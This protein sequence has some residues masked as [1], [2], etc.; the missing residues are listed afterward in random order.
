MIKKVRDKY[1]INSEDF[2]LTNISAMTQNK[3]VEDLLAAYGI[4]K[5]NK[6]LNLS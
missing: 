2:I 3:G 5:K 1:K 4:L 6:I